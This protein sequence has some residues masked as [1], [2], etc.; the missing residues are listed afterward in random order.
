MLSF[1]FWILIAALFSFT[2][3]AVFSGWIGLR[4]NN[5][6]I[7]YIPLSGIV[8][9]VF[10]RWSGVDVVDLLVTNWLWGVLAAA[11]AAF[12]A[13]RNVLRQKSYP[14]RTGAA[15]FL[16]MLWPGLAYGAV[17]GLLLSVLPI[18]AV[19]RGLAESQWASGFWGEIAIG[20]LAMLASLLITIVYHL[21][22]PEFRNKRVVWTLVGNGL[23]SLAFLVS[24]N[25]L[26]AVL[27][28]IAMHM[29]AMWHGRET[30][31]QLPPHRIETVEIGG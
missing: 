29:A 28:H 24:G 18:M 9:Y 8:L 25:F 12:I 20:V 14:R 11:V 4:R 22:Y 17:D 26:A 1:G 10:Y 21:G 13:V 5:F 19:T 23:F 3:S 2:I 30:T 15:F 27:P 7:L 16:D 31:V 6:L